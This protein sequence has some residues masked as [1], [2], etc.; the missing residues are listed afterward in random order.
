MPCIVLT[1]ILPGKSSV[2]VIHAGFDPNPQT[3]SFVPVK[4]H[5]YLPLQ[6]NMRHLS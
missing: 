3:D 2:C 4:V 6:P 1:G 5:M